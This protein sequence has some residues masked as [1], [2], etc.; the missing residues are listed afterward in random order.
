MI[1]SRALWWAIERTADLSLS[2]GPDID[3]PEGPN[4]DTLIPGKF[5][6]RRST[7]WPNWKEGMSEEG[8]GPLYL[9]RDFWKRRPTSIIQ[10]LPALV[11]AALG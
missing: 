7:C 8:R 10:R 3:A 9:T 2:H 6:V 11:R 1:T 4:G 5:D